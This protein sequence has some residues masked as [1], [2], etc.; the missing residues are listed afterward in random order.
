LTTKIMAL[1]DSLGNL[2]DFRLMPG[3]RHD[4]QG[5][6]ALIEGKT[7]GAFLGTRRS[8]MTAAGRFCRHATRR[9]SFPQTKPH[10]TDR[11]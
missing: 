9:R 2:I 3:Q 8:T 6:T 4:S 7:F 5:V 1:V 10:Q 11:V